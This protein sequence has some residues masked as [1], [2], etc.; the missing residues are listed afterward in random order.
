MQRLAMGRHR[1]RAE[2][3]GHCL[4]VLFG[5]SVKKMEE[6]G[7]RAQGMED[8]MAQRWWRKCLRAFSIQSLRLLDKR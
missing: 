8:K 4:V 3:A 6:R 2:S 5:F 7:Q 1:G